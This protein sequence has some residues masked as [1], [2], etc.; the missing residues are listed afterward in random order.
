MVTMD[1]GTMDVRAYCIFSFDCNT[2]SRK[3]KAASVAGYQLQIWRVHNKTV[4]RP[5]GN[6][7]SPPL[8]DNN[9]GSCGLSVDA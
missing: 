5:S 4:F 3:N 6:E 7:L 9:G 1:S 2:S 8:A